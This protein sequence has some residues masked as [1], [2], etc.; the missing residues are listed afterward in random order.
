[1]HATHAVVD[2]DDGS[3]S[4]Q[5]GGKLFDH[6]TAGGFAAERNAELKPPR[7][8]FE[9]L[10]LMPASEYG[11]YTALANERTQHGEG[12]PR[13]VCPT[14]GTGDWDWYHNDQARCVN[15][16]TWTQPPDDDELDETEVLAR[17]WS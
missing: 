11:I 6:A 14:C 17:G 15:G 16:H 4:W 10:Y 9:V 1:M 7:A 5:Q 12:L 13:P 2:T 3:M 8:R